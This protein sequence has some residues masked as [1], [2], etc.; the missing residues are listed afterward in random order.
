M[1]MSK[2]TFT[3]NLLLRGKERYSM[4]TSVLCVSSVYTILLQIATQMHCKCVPIC[5]NLLQIGT[6]L[7]CKC[8]PIC[9]NLLQIGMQLHYICV[10]ICNN[11]LQIKTLLQIGT[12]H[13]SDD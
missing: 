5:N 2:P 8:A 10:P 7:Q 6:Q 12:Q 11:L 1:T 4:V 9:N 3:R 13:S